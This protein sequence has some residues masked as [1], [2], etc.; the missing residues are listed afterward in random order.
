VQ[1]RRRGGPTTG[2]PPRADLPGDADVVEPSNAPPDDGVVQLDDGDTPRWQGWLVPAAVVAIV[3]LALFVRMIHLTALGFNSDEA[4]YT[5]QAGSLAGVGDFARNFSPFRAHPLALQTVLAMEFT[6][7]GRMSEFASRATVV[8]TGVGAVYAT[9]RIGRLLYGTIVGLA[10]ALALAIVPYHVFI[11]RQV[12]LDVPAGLAVLLAFGA[13]Y[14]YDGPETR[15][16][17][18]LAGALAG[19]ACLIKETMIVFAPAALLYLIWSGLWRRTRLRDGVIALVLMGV[20]LLPFVSTRFLFSGSSAGGYIIYQLFREPNHP[21]WYFPVVF[22]IFVTPVATFAVAYGVF[23]AAARRTRADKLLLSWL[24]VFGAFFQFWP[25]KLL[26]YAIVLVPAMAMVG[27]RGVVDAARRLRAHRSVRITAIATAVAAAAILAPMLGPTWRAG[28]V[29][30]DS[31]FSGPLTTDVEVQ[32]FAGGREVGTWFADHT[33]HNATVLT[34][35][36]SLGNLVS[37]YGDR[38]FF[39]LSV[40]QDEKLRNPAYR[41]IANPDSD[42]R[43]MQVQYAVWDAYTADRSPYYSG[44]LMSYVHKYSGTPVYSVWVAGNDVVTGRVAPTGAEVR[45]VVYQ[46]V[47]GD[48]LIGRHQA[49]VGP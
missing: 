48:P 24:V 49:L 29:I 34:M 36:P 14:R 45:I 17:L 12:L 18:Y 47:G 27:A 42:I 25:T 38:D 46:L 5:G 6:L 30:R 9:Y 28:A 4:V 13:L 41:P 11:S 3:G 43:Q 37:F 40:S 19:V 10:A 39:A 31:S 1:V 7:L 44:K 8:V 33:P 21:A 23:I 15:R 16:L 26:P 32:D 2:V 20:P 22:W 35:G